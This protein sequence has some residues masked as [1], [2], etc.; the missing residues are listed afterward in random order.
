MNAKKQRDKDRRRANRLAEEAWQAA[1]QDRF[2]LAA[3]IIRRAVDLNPSSPVLWHDQGTFL[4]RMRQE[5]GAARA[6]QTAIQ[7]APDFAEAYASLAALRASQGKMEQA[8]AIQS[9]AA[10]HAPDSSRHGDALACYKALL[11]DAYRAPSRADDGLQMDIR[12]APIEMPLHNQW[13][14]LAAQIER[15]DWDDIGHQL[16]SHGAAHVA[17]L[18]E[19]EDCEAIR[20]M[21]GQDQRFAKTVVMNKSR[22]GK[23]VY[24]YFAHPLPP[25]IDAIRRLFYPRVSKIANGWQALLQDAE[26]FPPSWVEFRDQCAAAGQTTPSPL[27]LQYDKGGFNSLHQDIR[28]TV[29]FPIQLVM[30]L[31]PRATPADAD[32]FTGGEFLL[33]DDTRRQAIPAGLGDAILFCTCARLVRVGGGYGL[34]PVKHGMSQIES[35]SRFAVGIPFHEFR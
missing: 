2:D 23:G 8:V 4:A 24:R 3:R 18:L 21:F 34:Q 1:E 10:R 32:G 12:S 27:L 33:C 6:F 17:R 28:G 14:E 16:T 19:S 22:F 26:R 29:F 13:P 7:L 5:D 35:G 25:V 15:L 11:A 20:S 31:S 30:V 9:E